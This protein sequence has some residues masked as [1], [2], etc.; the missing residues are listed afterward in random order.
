MIITTYKRKDLAK[1]AVTS[2]MHQDYENLEII[3]IE[4]GSNSGIEAWLASQDFESLRY[5]NNGSNL[6]LSASRNRGVELAKGEY[7]AFLDDDDGWLTGKVSTQMAEIFRR[8]DDEKTVVTCGTC[9]LENGT[10]IKEFVP[11]IHSTLINHIFNGGGVPPSSLIIPIGVM[12]RIGGFSKDLDSCIDHDL[13]MN[14][15]LAGC[16]I[17]CISEG[18]VYTNRTHHEH[19][20]SDMCQRINGIA[21]FYNKWSKTVLD[22]SGICS[23][24]KIERIYESQTYQAIFQ[25]LWQRRI[26]SQ[27]ASTYLENLY[28]LRREFSRNRFLIQLKDRVLLFSFTHRIIAFLIHKVWVLYGF[29]RKC[30]QYINKSYLKLKTQE[31]RET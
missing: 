8:G 9:V 29:F 12:E 6:G 1:L 7:V 5:D 3:V 15:S 26:E 24:R 31:L 20:M 4:D 30:I 14:L 13:W 25:K 16:K 18:L 23:W 22:V 10:V 27:Q 2:V 17:A 21:Q 28:S 11:K 19:M